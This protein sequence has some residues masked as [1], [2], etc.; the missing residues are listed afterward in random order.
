MSKS[1]QPRKSF[2]SKTFESQEDFEALRQAESFLAERGFSV[3]SM[4][5]D[6]PIGVMHGNCRIS[7]WLNLSHEDRAS[8]HGILAVRGRHGPATITIYEDAP[9]SAKSALT[10]SQDCGIARN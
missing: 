6:E 10:Q 7:K 1:P 2:F 5:G 9:E 8:L 4:Q 3:G